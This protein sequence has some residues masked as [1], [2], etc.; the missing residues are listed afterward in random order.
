MNHEGTGLWLLWKYL[1]RLHISLFETSPDHPEIRLLTPLIFPEDGANQFIDQ[2]HLDHTSILTGGHSEVETPQ[3]QATFLAVPDAESALSIHEPNPAT[4][5]VPS[6]PRSQAQQES[7]GDRA[8]K[9]LLRAA[10]P[11]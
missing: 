5:R 10:Q 3:S 11:Q 2:C 1:W 7:F 4:N 8:A 9:F 6:A